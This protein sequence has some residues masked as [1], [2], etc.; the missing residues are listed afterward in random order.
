MKTVSTVLLIL[1][2]HFVCFSQNNE[3]SWQ[4]F[5]DSIDILEKMGHKYPE[6]ES[7]WIAEILNELNI[8]RYF[9]FWEGPHPVDSSKKFYIHINMENDSVKAKGYWT[10]NRFYQESFNVDSV[11]I[12]AAGLSFRIPDWDCTYRGTIKDKNH[13]V[14]GFAC[15]KEPFDNVNLVRNNLVKTYLTE[16][17][18]G[19]DKKGFTYHYHQPENVD[20]NI[21]TTHCQTSNDSAFIHSLLSEIIGGSYGR[22][23]SFLLFKNNQLVCEEYFYGYSKNDAHPI[24]SCTKSITSLLIG[25]A[26]DKGY[27]KNLNKPLNSVFQEY[28]HLNQGKYCHITIRHLLT[29]T[30]GF[31][32]DNENLFK[33]GN[34]IAFALNRDVIENPGEKFQYDGGNTEILGGILKQKTGLFADE[35]AEKYLFEP[36]KI[37]KFN[38]EM[39]KQNGYPGMAGALHLCP[40]DMGK[41]GMLILNKGRFSGNQVVSEN[42][43]REST[44]VKTKSNKQGDDYSYQWWN[45]NLKSGNKSYKCIW[46]N[47]WGSQFIYIFPDLDVVIVTTGHN[48]DSDSWAIT[49]GISKYL[50]LL[51]N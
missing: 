4:L 35:F 31:N 25:I 32:P 33:S 9:G 43:I 24:E 22:M 27:I 42:W 26:K 48:Y 41:I 3:Q 47:G 2:T 20:D 45:L 51:E 46:A 23:N 30:S 6:N 1:I 15:L 50:Y 37:T 7:E 38:W 40:R 13:I 39:N 36:L 11:E 5:Q 18:P 16:P 10:N 12:K 29:M 21:N 49:N 28:E 44:S 19:S 14:G 8:Y 34:R 17:L